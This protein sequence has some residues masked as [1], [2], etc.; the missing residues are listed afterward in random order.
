[1]RAV[2]HVPLQRDRR[3]SSPGRGDRARSGGGQAT[4]EFALVIGLVMFIMLGVVDL[5]R[6]VAMQ[7][8]IVTAS[9][10]AARYG[11][12]V[13]PAAGSSPAEFQYTYC[14]GI[15]NAARQIIGALVTVPDSAITISYDQGV[16]G[17]TTTTS[18][19]ASGET[20]GPVPTEITKFDRVVVQVTATYSPISAVR[21]AI[22]SITV[23][24][25][26]RRT[27]VK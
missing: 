7:S 12:A 11:S 20:P 25:L 4:A 19:P 16:V 21:F 2:I 18:C 5:G 6:L 23:T 10:E 1:M 8:A 26:D 27:I 13:G 24:S 14:T 17:T 3:A 22:P 9:R 15:R